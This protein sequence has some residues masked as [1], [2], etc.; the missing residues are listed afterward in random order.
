MRNTI[1][2]NEKDLQE[3]TYAKIPFA[4][5][6][7]LDLTQIEKD[8]LMSLFCHKDG[9]KVSHNQISKMFRQQRRVGYVSKAIDRLKELKYVVENKGNYH[10]NITQIREDYE[11]EIE[12][13]KTARKEEKKKYN[14]EYYEASKNAN[15]TDLSVD[16][17]EVNT[18]PQSKVKQPETPV[19]MVE[20]VAETPQPQSKVKDKE[21]YYQS[22]FFGS[23]L[24]KKISKLY[25]ESKYKDKIS[26]SEFEKL[27]TH[28]YHVLCLSNENAKHMVTRD[29]YLRF[30]VAEK[31]QDGIPII[32]SGIDVKLL[33]DAE[34]MKNIDKII[35]IYKL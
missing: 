17:P 13:I 25:E 23:A 8:V 30:L 4:Q 32:L 21:T 15:K 33:N 5:I 26:Y 27:F 34:K 31:T 24:T 14:K 18:T 11:I 28:T 9:F 6:Q 22:V 20:Q 29:E 10:I 12:N 3:F 35:E 7:M 19:K 2:K 16:N 1:T